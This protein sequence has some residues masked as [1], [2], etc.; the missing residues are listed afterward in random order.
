MYLICGLMLYPSEKK[1][2]GHPAGSEGRARCPPSGAP[3]RAAAL[4]AH[5]PG[6]RFT[7]NIHW[8]TS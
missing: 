8:K 2:T 1:N 4:V 6:E 7:G 5:P 3:H